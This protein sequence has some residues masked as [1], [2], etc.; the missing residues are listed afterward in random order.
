MK[1]L[2]QVRANLKCLLG[3]TI[4]TPCLL[5]LNHSG[6]RAESIE[7]PG[8]PSL[9]SSLNL[10]MSIEFCGE[11]VPMQRPEIR[12]RFEKE[13]LLS[14][15][16]RPQVILWLKRS[17]RYFTHIGRM[18]REH[19]LPDDLKYVAVAESALLPHIGSRKGAMGF[20]QFMPATGRKYGLVVNKRM[21]ER[22]NIFA[23]TLAATR[24]FRKLHSDFKSWTLA[25]AAYN[26]GEEGLMADISEQNTKD[27]YQLYLPLETQRFLFRILAVKLIFEDPGRYG[28]NLSEK[29]YYRPLA[30]DRVDMTCAQETPI[31]VVAQAA[32]TQFK[33][34]KDLNPEIR[35]YYI[36]KGNHSILIPKGASEGFQSRY[37]YYMK[38][39]LT[40][41]KERIYIVRKG[42]NLSAIAERFGIPLPILIIRNRIDIDRPIHPGDRLVIY[43][44]E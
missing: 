7:P 31:R 9:L 22:R 38:K 44:S 28:F 18:L 12:E 36:A 8:F 33:V 20:W 1:T 17:G 40:A 35:G 10:D 23:S 14:L 6:I 37:Q 15:W 2:N 43:G 24:Y 16:N 19:G 13:L 26:M 32:R 27:Y 21:D 4:L 29:D 30:F 25:A 41:E 11:K 3:W 42:D 39:S 5:F 34:I